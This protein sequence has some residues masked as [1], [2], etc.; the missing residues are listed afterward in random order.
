VSTIGEDLP[1]FD[2]KHSYLTADAPG[3]AAAANQAPPPLNPTSPTAL[4]GFR[5]TG[6]ATGTVKKVNE[7]IEIC[8]FSHK[9]V[10]HLTPSHGT[11]AAGDS[12]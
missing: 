12:T 2:R 1:F 8:H 4:D 9:N 10:S 5:P 3:T 11:V 7:M 6:N